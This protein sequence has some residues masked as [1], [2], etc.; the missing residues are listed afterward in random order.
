MSES[1]SV[2]AILTADVNNFMNGF[3]MAKQAMESFQMGAG[4]L[5]NIS[6]MAGVV[7]A[8]L[9][10]GL[11]LPLAG[12]GAMS[13]KT[14]G[15]FE[16]QMNRVKAISGATGGEFM[17]LKDQAM[18]LG[19]ATIFSASEVA[20][21]QEMMASAGF[22]V[23]EIFGAMPGVM[24]LA[25]VSSGDMALASEAVA[26]AMN[27]FGLSGSKA[28]HVADVYARA[29]ADTNAETADMAEAMKYA[30]PVAGALG[31]SIE[32]TAAAIG[33]MSNAGIKG[34]QAGT[35]L[36]SALSRLA[37]PT[38]EAKK[39]M[40]DLG[41]NVFDANGKMLP[42]SETIP[43]LQKAFSGLTDQQKQQAIETLFGKT[44]M[45]GMLA[46]INSA[47]GEFDSLTTSLENSTGAAKEMA[48]IMNSGLA[49]AIEEL[50]G[51]LETAG[52]RIGEILSEMAIKAVGAIQSIVDGFNGLSPAAQEMVV[53]IGLVAAA[54]GP[55]LLIFSK[56]ISAFT[57]VKT[58]LAIVV[59]AFAGFKAILAGTATPLGLFGKGLV[60]VKGGLTAFAA[61]IGLANVPL[62][63]LVAGLAAVAVGTVA[64]VNHLNE[65]SLKFDLFGNKVS[66]GTKKA[67]TAFLDLENHAT[68][69]LNQLSWSGKAV[70]EEMANGIIQNFQ[71]M[72]DQVVSKLQEQ[73]ASSIQTFQ[74]MYNELGLMQDTATR[75]KIAQIG[76]S[77]DQ[78]IMAEQKGMARVREILTAAKDEKRALTQQEATEI[79]TI[80]NQMKNDGIRI[81]S[82]SE[83][84]YAVIMQRMK[85]NA[86]M[87]SAQQAAEVVQ[88]SLKQKEE[89]VKN[90]EQEYNERIKLAEQLRAQ[91]GQKN[92]ELADEIIK[93]AKKA[94]DGAV[95]E[96]EDMHQ[97]V[98]SEAQKQA[99]E[100]VNKVDW[101]TGQVKSKWDVMRTAIEDAVN[102]FGDTVKSRLAEMYND[103]KSKFE[104]M[105]QAASEK[106]GQ[107]KKDIE[108]KF[109]EAKREAT[110]A[111]NNIK[112]AITDAFTQ[113]VNTVKNKMRDV[114]NSVKEGF[115]NALNA[116]RGFISRA[117]SV[118][119]D[120]IQGFVNGV[121]AAAGRLISAVSSAV[122]GAINR[123]KA[124][125]RIGSPSKLFKQFG[126]WTLEGYA[127]GLE[128]EEKTV[129]NQMK[130]T[131]KGISDIANNTNLG[132]LSNLSSLSGS[133]NASIEHSLKDNS[134]QPK[135]AYINLSLG[136]RNYRAFVE[137]IS[138]IQG[139]EANLEE[140]FGF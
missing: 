114:V 18:E 33:I 20:E 105:K 128:K 41:I 121:K 39:L 2:K 77:Y 62:V 91:G 14:F 136:G 107:I 50:K 104:Q 123:A 76:A 29:A 135:P 21:G 117:V 46:L 126:G 31:I 61:A 100:H 17:K 103:L 116:A 3:G 127:I 66:E 137:D 73:K 120:L 68:T 53:K 23:N 94:K 81:L 5:Q 44:A 32:E 89:T 13:L 27:Q 71:T 4:N 26:S 9:T 118:G 15:G 95:E 110:N 97:K 22:S 140:A 131:I 96:A 47:P 51:S 10:K 64:L 58:A 59:P 57:A 87:L 108:T 125:L 92:A 119:R 85:D 55:M 24:D 43:I 139:V 93:Q 111:V 19:A 90:A 12:I 8:G 129:F 36:R 52:I 25:A 40:N 98:V 67:V 130:S 113:V 1:Y 7:G 138:N 56:L 109:N 16:K 65:S 101:E 134:G 133:T 79:N 6:K 99:E 37:A 132:D 42:M 48:D 83:Q 35:T 54:I 45:S 72:N 60:A 74:E 112:T 63:A 122:S 69:S 38:S 75:E 88:N 102:G 11:T 106:I 78:Q 84:E 124:L 115:S 49:G 30:G 82:E 80:R 70:T 34:S 86:G 28:A